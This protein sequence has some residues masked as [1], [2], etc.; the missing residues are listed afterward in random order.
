V[1]R[2]DHQINPVV[3]EVFGERREH[4]PAEVSGGGACPLVRLDPAQQDIEVPAAIA[5]E[6]QVEGR[7][8]HGSAT[9]LDLGQ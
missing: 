8:V 1:R 9:G 4:G 2:H 3:A 7:V 6:L 5:L